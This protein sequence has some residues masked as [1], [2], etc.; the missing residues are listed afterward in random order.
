ALWPRAR[1]VHLV[2]DGRD[3]CLSV[4][5]WDHAY[6]AAGRYSTWG[7]DPVLTTA[8]WWER[9][10]RLGRQG[11]QGLGPGLYYELR[12]ED[13][14]SNPGNTCAS[15]CDFLGVPYDE[16]MLRFHEGRT[17]TEPGLDAKESW[18]PITPGLR[19]WRTQMLP[20]DVERFEAAAGG[21]L[22]ELGYPRKFTNPSLQ[23]LEQ[24]AKLREALARE[25]CSREAVMPLRR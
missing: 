5:N 20:E 21:L 9:K 2:R 1:V 14:V 8:L 17:R 3:V 25:L 6:K 15:L 16:S 19:N 22:T 23:C 7:E 10:V 11:G 12:Y 18:L 24:G 4:L 13:L